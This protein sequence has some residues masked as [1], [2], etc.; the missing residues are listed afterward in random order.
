MSRL[1]IKSLKSSRML[2]LPMSQM[3]IT[4]LLRLSMLE[5]KGEKMLRKQELWSPEKSLLTSS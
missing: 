5:R 2:K 1:Q 3:D 4:E